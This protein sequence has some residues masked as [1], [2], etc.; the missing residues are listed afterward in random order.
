LAEEYNEDRISGAM[1]SF[2]TKMGSC[3]SCP[4]LYIPVVIAGIDYKP[5]SK[6]ESTFGKCDS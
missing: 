6:N 5:L 4:D 1:K 3:I 2:V